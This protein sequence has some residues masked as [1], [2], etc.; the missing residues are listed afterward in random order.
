[1]PLSDLNVASGRRAERVPQKIAENVE[2]QIV[3]IGEVEYTPKDSD[4]TSQDFVKVPNA[5]STKIL[6]ALIPGVAGPERLIRNR[7]L[8]T[9]YC[10]TTNEKPQR[11]FCLE[12]NEQPCDIRPIASD[13]SSELR[14]L[15]STRNLFK[16]LQT[17]GND[18]T[19]HVKLLRGHDHCLWNYC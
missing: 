14:Y 12:V 5:R 11:H 3:D 1:M 13:G 9:L 7:A 6:N 8:R 10:Q 19:L 4:L 17:S 2:F 18:T 15:H 16:Y